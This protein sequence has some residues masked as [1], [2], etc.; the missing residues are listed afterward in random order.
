M[1]LAM[2]IFYIIGVF[3]RNTII[4]MIKQI[5]DIEKKKAE[6]SA[7]LLEEEKMAQAESD[8]QRGGAIDY[9]VGDNNTVAGVEDDFDDDIPIAKII[10]QQFVITSYSIHYTKL[11][12]WW[13]D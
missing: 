12:E 9:T 11:Y 4:G 8:E 6:E 13:R 5:K 3:F 7:R 10:R 2:I 1:I